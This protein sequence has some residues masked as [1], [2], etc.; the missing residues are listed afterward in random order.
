[1][2]TVGSSRTA[3]WKVKRR[4][5]AWDYMCNSSWSRCCVQNSVCIFTFIIAVLRIIFFLYLFSPDKFIQVVTFLV[6]T[7]HVYNCNLS[8]DTDCSD[9][10]LACFFFSPFT[11][12]QGQSFPSMSFPFH[13]S[14][15]SS[16]SPVRTDLLTPSLNKLQMDKNSFP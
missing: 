14:Q 10:G 16:Y 11:K 7:P 5:T 12:I 8:R 4:E 1:M 6:C 3:R 2:R 13:Y 15:S 9:W